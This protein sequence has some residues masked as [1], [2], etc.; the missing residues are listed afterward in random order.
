[1][2]K[3]A[4]FR[5]AAFERRRAAL[6]S[7]ECAALRLGFCFDLPASA[8]RRRG[9]KERFFLCKRQAL[10]THPKDPPPEGGGSERDGGRTLPVQYL[11]RETR[12]GGEHEKQA[13]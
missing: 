11:D 13:R 7:P 12:G 4:Q 8:K 10:A 1:M 5:R 6:F 3:G 2:I 9:N